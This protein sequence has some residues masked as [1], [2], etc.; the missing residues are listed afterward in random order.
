MKINECKIAVQ[1]NS[2]AGFSRSSALGARRT[3]KLRK[4]DIFFNGRKAFHQ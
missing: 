2:L 4:I 1:S 3:Q